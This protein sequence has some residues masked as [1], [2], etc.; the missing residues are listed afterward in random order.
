MAIKELETYGKSYIPFSGGEYGLYV[1]RVLEP[2]S[3]NRLVDFVHKHALCQMSD[4]DMESLHCTIMYSPPELLDIDKIDHEDLDPVTAPCAARV[5]RFEMWPGHDEEGYLV[6]SLD[7]PSLQT[8]H[9]LWKLRGCVSTYP[10]EYK[11]HI[12]IKTPFEVYRGLT[13]RLKAVNDVLAQSPMI[14]RLHKEAVEDIRKLK[15]VALIE[16]TAC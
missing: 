7:S 14:V 12:T 11:P 4:R 16:A 6:A 1:S 3:Q 8:V 15:R 10:N 2:L 5:I 13:G 9:R